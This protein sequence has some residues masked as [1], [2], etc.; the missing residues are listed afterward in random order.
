MAGGAGVIGVAVVGSDVA[1]G[2]VVVVVVVVTEGA[3]SGNPVVGA[4]TPPTLLPL[5]VV[6]DG[7][8][9]VVA[10]PYVPVS[11]RATPVPKP[12][13]AMPTTVIIILVSV[14]RTSPLSRHRKRLDVTPDAPM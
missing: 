11:A 6:P 8:V 10:D 1:G 5:S 9:V 3:G 12:S 4:A 2:A 14:M 13:A 7:V